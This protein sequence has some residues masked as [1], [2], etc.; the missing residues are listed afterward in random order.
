MLLPVRPTCIDIQASGTHN[1]ARTD[2]SQTHALDK[3]NLVLG[4]SDG[5][6]LVYH[7]FL[8]FIPQASSDEASIRALAPRRMHWHRGPVN[9]VRW[10]SD[11]M[12]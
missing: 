6:I 12:V 1:Q 7:D 4:N 3:M 2:G 9:V 10:S 11:G 5:S 8:A